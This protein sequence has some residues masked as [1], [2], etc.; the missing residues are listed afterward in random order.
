LRRCRR[1]GDSCGGSRIGEQDGLHC[2][3][4]REAAVR[5]GSLTL[6]ECRLDGGQPEICGRADTGINTFSGPVPPLLQLATSRACEALKPSDMNFKAARGQA[7]GASLQACAGA[8]PPHRGHPTWGNASCG[9]ATTFP[10]LS[11]RMNESTSLPSQAHKD[12]LLD[13]VREMGRPYLS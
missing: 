13:L 1:A 3:G 7:R 6:R 2:Q 8:L 11:Y 12:S 10:F 4:P 9:L 5:L